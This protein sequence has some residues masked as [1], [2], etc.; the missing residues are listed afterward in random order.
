MQDVSLLSSLSLVTLVIVVGY[1]VF[2]FFKV[3]Q[4][5]AKRGERPGGIAGPGPE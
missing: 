4:S 2:H 1:A 3:R 5:Q